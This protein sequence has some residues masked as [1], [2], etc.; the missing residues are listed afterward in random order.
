MIRMQDFSV[1]PNREKGSR[2]NKQSVLPSTQ[3]E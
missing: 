2:N 1:S 3:N